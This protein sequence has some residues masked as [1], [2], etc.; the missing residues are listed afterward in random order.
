MSTT[1]APFEYR[2]EDRKI[3]DLELEDF[4]PHRVYDAHAHM[5]QRKHVSAD[6]LSET[7]FRDVDFND[8]KAFHNAILP[9]R[10][11]HSIVLGCPALG[12]DVHAHNTFIK[13]QT[14]DDPLTRLHRLTTP[15]CTPQEIER[16]VKERGFVGLKVY[17]M[18]A[19]SGDMKEC[20]IK[21]FLLEEQMEVASELGLW[22]TLHM[23]RQGGCGDETNLSDLEDYTRRYPGI[24]WILAH[25]AR[26]FN[27]R[28]IRLGIDRLRAMPNIFYDLSAVTDVRPFITLF[29]KEN[30]DRLLFGT[31]A[32]DSTGYHGQY[33]AFGQLCEGD[34]VLERQALHIDEVPGMS[35]LATADRPIL[36]IY[37]QM[38]S[39]KH[40]AEIAGLSSDQ[41]ED[42]FWRNATREFKL[43]WPE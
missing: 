27:Y 28:P 39:M 16:D 8:L 24:K 40:A 19:V 25:C 36:C 21:E 26:S 31:D 1:F 30:T 11:V 20:R 13:E 17:R 34:E 22:V 29:K 14:K 38:L 4:V 35:F 9:G 3:W 32:I 42:I 12:I 7:K 43:D 33:T 37:E 5:F 15:A 23:S 6:K 41:I 2:P 18:F 10:D